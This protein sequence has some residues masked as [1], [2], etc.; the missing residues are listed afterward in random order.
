M[1]HVIPYLLLKI[2]N[3]YNNDAD[4]SQLLFHVHSAPFLVT[5]AAQ[6][7]NLLLQKPVEVKK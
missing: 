2:Y 6:F 3:H 7:T 4:G 5:L 1:S